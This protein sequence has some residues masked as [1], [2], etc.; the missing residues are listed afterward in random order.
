MTDA[1][2]WSSALGQSWRDHLDELEATL[3]PV[4]DALSAALDLAGAERVADIGCGGG[5]FTQHLAHAD[6][7]G[8]HITGFD[9]SSDLIEAARVRAGS[10]PVEFVC[11]NAQTHVLLSKPFDRLTS[12]YG[13]MFFQDERVAFDN[14]KSWLKPGGRFAFA[15]WADF[16]KNPWQGVVRDVVKDFIDIPKALPNQPSAVRYADVECFIT[17]LENTG[18]SNV[19]TAA[20]N[21]YLKLGGGLL[22]PDAAEFGLSAFWGQ[23][24][25]RSSPSYEH[26]LERLTAVLREHEEAD[27]VS[28]PACVH[29]VTGQI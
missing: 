10:L 22:A 28:M 21:G 2:Q 14:L 11:A 23:E 1:S 26:A 12:R 25:P 13:I 19:S 4:N 8:A 15:V 6:H 27:E 9:I 7:T 24:L 20:W 3:A 29:I 16:A 5:G 18:F 17:L